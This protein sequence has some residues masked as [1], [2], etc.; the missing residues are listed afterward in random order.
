MSYQD[1]IQ[2]EILPIPDILHVGLTNCCAN[3]MDTKFGL[4]MPDWPFFGPLHRVGHLFRTKFPSIGR[5]GTK[6]SST[7]AGKIFGERPSNTGSC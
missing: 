6:G 3:V 5:I 7:W 4:T 1:K 2:R